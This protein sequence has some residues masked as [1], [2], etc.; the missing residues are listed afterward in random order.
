MEGLLY[1]LIVLLVIVIVVIL[2][3]KFLFAVILVGGIYADQLAFAPE[4]QQIE[5]KHVYY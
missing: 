1:Q 5:L 4:I 2:L 3:L